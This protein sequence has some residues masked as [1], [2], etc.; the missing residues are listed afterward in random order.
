MHLYNITLMLNRGAET[1][2]LTTNSH[3]QAVGEV[4][5]HISTKHV[6]MYAWMVMPDHIHLLFGREEPMDVDD[7]AGLVKRRINK[8]FERRGMQKMRWLDGCVKYDVTLETLR[9]ARDHILSNPVRGQLVA[10]AEDWPHMAAPTELPS[11]A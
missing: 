9:D 3:G 1:R 4:L 11:G 8:T 7:F 6:T 10:K 2:R 5:Q